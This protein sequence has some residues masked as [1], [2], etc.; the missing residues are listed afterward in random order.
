MAQSD[1]LPD[2][3]WIDGTWQR[4]AG[5]GRLE[6]VE[7]ATELPWAN[8]PAADKSDVDRAVEAAHRCATR[9]D[10]AARTDRAAVLYRIAALIREQADCIA[11]IESRNVGKPIGDARWEINAGAR[12]FEYY[13]GGISRFGGETIPVAAAGFDYT[14][15]VPVGVVAAIV[16]WN[17]PFLMACWKVAPALATG[18]AVILKPASL[19]PLSALS[20]A[21]VAEQAN[22]PG[23]AFQ[24]IAGRGSEIGDYLV[25]HP[26]VRKIAFTG[27]TATGSRILKLAA[28]DI[29]RV[30]LE[31]GGK[32]PN[33]IFADADVEAAAAAAPMSVFGNAGQDC[34]ARSRVIV[35]ES[36]YDRFLEALVEATRSL[37][38][39]DPAQDA[40]QVGPLV[41]AAQRETVEGFLEQARSDG[42]R[43]CCGATRLERPGYYLQPAVIDRLDSDSRV[44]QE[45][46]FGPV[47]C[48]LP[49]KTEQQAIELANAT[50]YGLSGSVWTRDVE[51]AVRV[52]R[53]IDSG[54]LSVN[55]NSSVFQEAPFGGFKRSGFGRDLGMEAMRLYT[56]VKNVFIALNPNEPS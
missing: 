24:V 34:C 44:C 27:E 19:T 2:A 56:E 50:P 43:I 30:S 39:D 33:V 14:L 55:T 38:V 10:W 22:V 49:F 6:P 45:E 31:L 4:E 18:N 40:T 29:K 8:V 21:H 20:L 13:A 7:P 46:I 25:S 32:S 54:V 5:G 51:R 15:R 1:S 28:D 36:V 3:L 52:T 42:G 17:F 26:L 9:G 41:S 48:V 53:A 35:E 12:C 23:D 47:A 16:P 11:Q 37:V